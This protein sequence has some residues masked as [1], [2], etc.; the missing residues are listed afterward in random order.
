MVS[1]SGGTVAGNAAYCCEYGDGVFIEGRTVTLSAFSIAK[2]ETAYELW[3]EVKQW[4]A[5][6]GYTFANPGREGNDGTAGD[7]PAPGA[8]TEPVTDI[9]W[10]DAVVWCNAYSEMSGKEPVYYTDTTYGAAL[11]TS[12]ND[13]GTNTAADQAV[14]KRAADGYRLPTE[15]EWEYAA[16]GGGVLAG[17]ST[18]RWAGTDTESSLGAYA[19]YRNNAYDVES[20]SPDYGAH[21]VGEKTANAA[22]LYDMS[23]NV[24][25]WCWDWYDSV[26]A[27][28]AADPA[29]AVSGADRVFRGGSWD[30]IAPLCAVAYRV[31]VDPSYRNATIGFRVVCP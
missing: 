15:A 29:G 25:E 23:G 9:N 28:T 13:G 10:R 5:G 21:P 16:R 20:G 19:W 31:S 3:Y 8:K 12:E 22:E 14:M 1:L 24:W 11:K 6:K 30:F 17:L 2:Y 26:D 27:G 4:A 18:D 7:P